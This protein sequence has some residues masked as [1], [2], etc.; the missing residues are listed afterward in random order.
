MQVCKF[1]TNVSTFRL[2]S[3]E[4]AHD[5]PFS[6]RPN[7]EYSIR[8]TDFNEI[9]QIFRQWLNYDVAGYIEEKSIPDLWKQVEGKYLLNP[10]PL[11]E[12][13]NS[14]FTLEEQKQVEESLERFKHLVIDEY[15]PSEEQLEIIIERL[16]YLASSMERLGKT[17]WQGVAISAILSISVALSLDT[18][19][20]NQL[21]VLFKQAFTIVLAHFR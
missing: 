21:F 11:S 15:S 10:D 7:D 1:C 4:D 16:N 13:N 17:D 6:H 9:K 5:D 3:R 14:A 20:G 19:K 12:V 8:W 2:L 18:A